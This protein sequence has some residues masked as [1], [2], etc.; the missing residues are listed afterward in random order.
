MDFGFTEEQELLRKSAREVLA[1]RSTPAVARAVMESETGFDE[2]LWKTIAE[3]G[4]CGVAIP[5]AE[6]GLG[7][8]WVEQAVLVEETGRAV[9]PAPYLST[10]GLAL[11]V[12]LL[13]EPGEMRSRLL[14]GIASGEM[15]VALALTEEDGEWFAPLKAAATKSVNGYTIEGR[16]VFVADA[17]VAHELL[18]VARLDDDFA[19]FAVPAAD[20]AITPLPTLDRTRR[21]SEVRLD[22]V[23]VGSERLIASGK[24]LGWRP[25]DRTALV[26]AAEQTGVAQRVLEMSVQYAKE[27]EQFGKPIGSFQAISHKLA[28]MLL[29]TE[30]ARSHV[31]YAAWAIDEG[32]PDASLAAASARVAGIEAGRF[33]TAEAIQVH[34]GIGFTYEHDL[35][36]FYRR[37]KWDELYYGDATVWRERVAELIAAT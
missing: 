35:H 2:S 10:V 27:R 5:E 31:Y 26:I 7:L 11:P 17:H 32:T 22:G 23:T 13:A 37:A 18:V 25:A 1:E 36:L 12:V 34:G 29:L 14:Q 24:S 19:V 4:W 6:G 33:A 8:G 15:R 30:S 20:T 3:L 9:L 16:K 21:L 28:D